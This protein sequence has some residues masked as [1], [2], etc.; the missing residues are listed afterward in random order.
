MKNI[1]RLE[2]R[3]M[4]S[5]RLRQPDLSNH[6]FHLYSTK[7]MKLAGMDKKRKRKKK[8]E[9]IPEVDRLVR[10]IEKQ[11]RGKANGKEI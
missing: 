9:M 2:M 8:I 6:D 4:L 10:E 7:Y 11:Q 3:Q 5:D 1:G